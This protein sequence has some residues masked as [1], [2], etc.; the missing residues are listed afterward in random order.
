LARQVQDGG[1]GEEGQ[2]MPDLLPVFMPLVALIALGYV[3][4]RCYKIDLK[5]VGTLLI[6]A[7]TPL[8]AFGS[9]AQLSFRRAYILLPFL[10]FALSC[11]TGLASKGMGRLFLRDKKLGAFLPEATGT[12]NSG[13]MGLPI[14]MAVFSPDLVG[15]YF[16]VMLGM[17]FFENSVGYYFIARGNI[18]S[19]EALN[20]VLRLPVLYAIVGGLVFSAWQVRLDPVFVK[21]W[22]ASKGAYVYFG[23]MLVGLALSSYKKLELHGDLFALTVLG[24]YVFWTVLAFALIM[25]DHL[26][27]RL[28]D[29]TIY[30]M[31]LLLG[32]LP[33]AANLTAIAAQCDFKPQ[34]AAPLV[35]LTVG[36]SFALLPIFLPFLVTFQ[37]PF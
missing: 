4:G 14:V 34:V 30:R 32:A 33:V 3:V 13:Y 18:S 22:D 19:R 26:V 11:L 12:C 25:I 6:F 23:M 20:R 37:P 16:L 35:V 15:V 1:V 24:R 27:W 28:F 9:T 31:F 7:V 8:V 21:L 10:S 17:L 29:V 2:R 5:S 36:V